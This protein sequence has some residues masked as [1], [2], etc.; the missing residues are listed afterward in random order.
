MLWR[1]RRCGDWKSSGGGGKVDGGRE[2][3]GRKIGEREG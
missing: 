2:L 1:G 3:S